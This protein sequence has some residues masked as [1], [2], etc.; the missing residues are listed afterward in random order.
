MADAN[1]LPQLNLTALFGRVSPELSGLTAG[2]ANAWGV[3]ASLAGPIFQGGLLRAQRRQALA[4]REQFALQYQAA[5]LN[6]MQ[7]V[8]NALMARQ[9]LAEARVQRT[10]AAAAYQEAV[11][12]SMERYRQGQSSY[13]EVLQEQQQLFPAQNALVQTQLDQLIASVQLYRALGGG[14]R[15]DAENR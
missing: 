10:L 3:A 2:G 1:F 11:R 9:K 12:V 8:S 14:W 13:Y 5:V 15:I 4:A 6:A 7:E